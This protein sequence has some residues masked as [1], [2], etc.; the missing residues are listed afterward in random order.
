MHLPPPR[1]K[2]KECKK[3]TQQLHKHVQRSI[4]GTPLA[5]VNLQ[6]IVGNV[7]VAVMM[8][9]RLTGQ[10]Y[11]TLND[12]DILVHSIK[13]SRSKRETQTAITLLS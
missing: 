11:S 3:G 9:I 10:H 7:F 1:A 8:K 13:P 6:D 12:S 2:E 4:S 5:E